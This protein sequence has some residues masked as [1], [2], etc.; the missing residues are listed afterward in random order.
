MSL[1]FCSSYQL[2]YAVMSFSTYVQSTEN[3][4]KQTHYAVLLAPEASQVRECNEV[5][6]S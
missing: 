6:L 2:K 5:F 1:W 3:V 4:L